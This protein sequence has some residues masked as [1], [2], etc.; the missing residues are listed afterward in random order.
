MFSYEN[1][2][3][4]ESLDAYIIDIFY[5]TKLFQCKTPNME[6]I[7]KEN[8]QIG[9]C[10]FIKLNCKIKN[11][12]TN[13]FLDM[14]KNVEKKILKNL[15]G[16]EYSIFGNL[17]DKDLLKKIISLYEPSY[18]LDNN[19]ILFTTKNNINNE[20]YNANII[21]KNIVIEDKKFYFLWVL[22]N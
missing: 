6:L 7:D 3:F 17:L 1:I 5:K 16:N 11:D 20:I 19:I 4:D 22:V 21:L 15:I 9:N 13:K 10:N 18:C 12:R 2:R 14:F 8:I